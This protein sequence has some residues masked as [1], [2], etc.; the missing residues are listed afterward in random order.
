M[1]TNTKKYTLLEITVDSSKNGGLRAA[2][3][4]SAHGNK[5]AL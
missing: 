4:I 5:G 1:R 3:G 2:V